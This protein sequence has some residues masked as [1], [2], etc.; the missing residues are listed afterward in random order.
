MDEITES[1]EDFEEQLGK[2]LSKEQCEL[3]VE[4][5]VNEWGG[6]VAA[7]SAVIDRLDLDIQTNEWNAGDD[8][9]DKNSAMDARN[10]KE[11]R[12]Y[13]MQGKLFAERKVI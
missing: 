1:L 11:L 12:K 9:D 13:L 6:Y 4:R 2:S 7:L 10:M 5:L 8:P 3:A